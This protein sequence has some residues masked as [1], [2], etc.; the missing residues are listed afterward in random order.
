[1]SLKICFRYI[2][3]PSQFSTSMKLIE[4]SSPHHQHP[5]PPKSLCRQRRKWGFPALWM[6]G[7][8]PNTRNRGWLWPGG[9][10]FSPLWAPVPPFESGNNNQL[11]PQG[12]FQPRVLWFW[13][14]IDVIT[15]S[16]KIRF[17]A[18][19]NSYSIENAARQNQYTHSFIHFFQ[20]VLLEWLLCSMR[21]HR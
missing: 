3:W 17:F 19:E 18:L 4:N 6:R 8:G 14:T 7:T 9:Q 11:D 21:W 5:L 12:F 2:F 20:Q 15:K 10:V 1:M 13:I 16:S